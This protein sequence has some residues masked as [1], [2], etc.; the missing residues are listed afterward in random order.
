MTIHSAMALFRKDFRLNRVPIIGGAALIFMP[1]LVGLIFLLTVTEKF[2]QPLLPLGNHLLNRVRAQ[3]DAEARHQRTIRDSFE[4]CPEISIVLTCA[5]AAIFG[6]AAFAYE[7]RERWADFLAMTPTPRIYSIISKSILSVLFLTPIWAFNV[8]AAFWLINVQ[9]AV[10]HEVDFLIASVGPMLMLFGVAWLI[11]S[12]A[13][14]PS[15]AACSSIGLFLASGL[16]YGL[17]VHHNSGYLIGCGL[18]AMIGVISFVCG[19]IY[20]VRR[21]EA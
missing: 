10:G 19:S 4:S 21:V 7:R 1:Y 9:A 13:S 6:G 11:S 12:F 14:S 17:Y 8:L 20:Y 2:P 3:E 15:I 16:L 5:T 18:C